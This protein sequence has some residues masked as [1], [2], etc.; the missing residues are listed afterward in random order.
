MVLSHDTALTNTSL[1]VGSLSQFVRGRYRLSVHSL[2]NLGNF[3]PSP[4]TTPS[5]A[6]RP[7]TPLSS[8]HVVN[9]PA[10]STLLRRQLSCVVNSPASSTLLRRQLSCVVNSPRRQLPRR[11]LPRRQLLHLRLH[12]ASSLMFSLDI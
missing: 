1:L 5:P 6:R 9:S 10:S 2:V 4:S 3:R 8:L 11:Q 7:S 12:V